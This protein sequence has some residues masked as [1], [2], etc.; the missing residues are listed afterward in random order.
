[1]NSSVKKLPEYVRKSKKKQN[2]AKLGKASNLNKTIS[3]GK[4]NIRK[5]EKLVSNQVC[6]LLEKDHVIADLEDQKVA[7]SNKLEK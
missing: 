6:D 4:I 2:A 7:L 5:L 1:M 3:N